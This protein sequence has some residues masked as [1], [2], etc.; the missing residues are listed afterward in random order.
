MEFMQSY[1]HL[2]KLCGEI[3]GPDRIKAYI[4]HMEACPQGAR[5]V[6][7]WQADLRQLRHYQWMRNQ[8]AHNVCCTEENMCS[9]EDL[10]WLDDFYMRI[11]SG[12]DPL[13]QY[14][15]AIQPQP[16]KAPPRP[17]PPVQKKKSNG[18]L[19]VAVVLLLAG[20]VIVGSAVWM[21][22]C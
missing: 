19:I 14:R 17:T 5:Y 15:R 18:L 1:K 8:I 7:S 13:T 10:Q 2:E 22:L 20:I 16:E 6:S 11:L 21:V 12:Q 4:A 9:Q 3:Y